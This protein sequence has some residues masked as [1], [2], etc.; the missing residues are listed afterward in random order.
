MVQRLQ[1]SKASHCSLV[2]TTRWSSQMIHFFS[3]YMYS[4]LWQWILRHTFNLEYCRS[5]FTW[6]LGWVLQEIMKANNWIIS[7]NSLQIS[8]TP[9]QIP[10][11]LTQKFQQNIRDIIPAHLLSRR[12][13]RNR[14]KH[15]SKSRTWGSKPTL[16]RN[17][18]WWYHKPNLYDKNKIQCKQH[19]ESQIRCN[20]DA[21]GTT[22]FFFL[23]FFSLS[24]SSRCC[25]SWYSLQIWLTLN[26]RYNFSKP[27]FKKNKKKQKQKQEVRKEGNLRL[28]R[29]PVDGNTST[30]GV[31]K[32]KSSASNKSKLKSD[33]TAL[34][35]ELQ[36]SSSSIVSLSL[37]NPD[38]HCTY[39]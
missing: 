19:D 9:D 13:R 21:F 2:F 1:P 31:S 11:S 12:T 26:P 10:P 4:L 8:E 38:D 36:I 27:T 28:W 37:T 32:T 34:R 15:R 29:T 35:L 25:K 22:D 17:S 6:N 23:F 7:H 14:S 20:S 18:S 39:D 30:M 24:L 16:C 3:T 33:A 5:C